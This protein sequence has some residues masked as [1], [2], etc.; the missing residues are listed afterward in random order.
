MRGTQIMTYYAEK[1]IVP[2]YECD[3][4]GAMH[5]SAAMNH[6]VLVSERQLAAHGLGPED[7]NRL[8]LGWVTTEYLINVTR[9]P[10]QHEVIEAR[11]EVSQYNKFFC[12][13]N[14]W[15]FDQAGNELVAVRS[16][17][18]VMSLS[19]RR[20]IKMPEELTSKYDAPFSKQV[21]TM[22][23]LPKLDWAENQVDKAYQVRYFDI[24]SNRHV[25]NA[26]YFDWMLDALTATFLRENQLQEMLIRYEHE[27][28]YGDQIQSQLIQTTAGDQMLTHH[29]ILNGTEIAAEAQVKWR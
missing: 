29:R 7:M 13:R 6:L 27:V 28:R 20:M 1:F 10:R 12:Y 9:L 4:A 2:F 11:T 15:L 17:W 3:P 16:T 26:H 25:N 8:A 21:L 14:Y 24:D 22:P 18:V 5:L 23:H 19:A